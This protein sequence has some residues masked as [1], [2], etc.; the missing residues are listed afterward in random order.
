MR[1]KLD[2]A[3]RR[4][5]P[6]DSFRQIHFAPAIELDGLNDNRPEFSLHGTTVDGGAHTQPL[7]HFRVNVAD[8]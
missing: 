6:L 7:F 3:H 4:E 2:A 8:G 1:F 5:A